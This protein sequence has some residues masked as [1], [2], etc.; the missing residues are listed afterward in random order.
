MESKKNGE[1]ILW[2]SYLSTSQILIFG[3]ELDSLCDSNYTFPDCRMKLYKHLSLKRS[4]I[5]LLECQETS[6]SRDSKNDV[7]IVSDM[8]LF[9]SLDFTNRGPAIKFE[10]LV[11]AFNLVNYHR[12]SPN[13]AC[14]LMGT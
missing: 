12:L 8:K 6:F 2:S 4:T 1:M 10:P 3:H 11:C 13:H 7:A 9:M 5:L 14:I